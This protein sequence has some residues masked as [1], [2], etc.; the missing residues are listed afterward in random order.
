MYSLVIITH[1]LGPHFHH[2]VFYLPDVLFIKLDVGFLHLNVISKT[3]LHLY[4][5]ELCKSSVDCEP[6]SLPLPL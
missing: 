4:I 2:S 6:L 5:M 3:R 1:V